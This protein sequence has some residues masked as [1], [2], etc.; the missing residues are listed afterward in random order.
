MKEKS[1]SPN[2]VEILESHR[3]I[4]SFLTVNQDL[5][6]HQNLEGNMSQPLSRMVISKPHSIGVLL[7]NIDQNKVILVK[8]YRYPTREDN[9][10]WTTEIV[11][12]NID[13]GETIDEC[14]HRE[15]LEETGYR[16]DSSQFIGQGYSSPGICTEK[17][18]LFYCEVNDEM[19]VSRGGGVEE[20]GED[21]QIVE[22]PVDQLWNM[23]TSHQFMDL[24]TQLAVQ[25]FFIHKADPTYR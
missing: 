17:L 11:A 25:W 5:I 2:N 13:E 15:V 22:W 1:I 8:Q 19:K 10:G 18:Y 12:G 3:L 16:L 21:I 24:K 20:E 6:R 9:N 14:V 7:L 23:L 4:D